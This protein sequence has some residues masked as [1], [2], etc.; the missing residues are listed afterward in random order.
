[1]LLFSKKKALSVL[2]GPPAPRYA[3]LQVLLE[4]TTVL[5]AWGDA[6]AF[7]LSCPG[8]LRR[9]HAALQ[10][11]SQ[12]TLPQCL[13]G[14]EAQLHAFAAGAVELRARMFFVPLPEMFASPDSLARVWAVCGGAAGGARPVHLRFGGTRSAR[15]MKAARN[16]LVLAENHT[17]PAV[18]ASR[19]P[20][21][22]GLVV[23]ALMRRLFTYA[24]G[25][26]RPAA[27]GGAILPALE[28]PPAL[29][30]TDL[31]GA[32]LLHEGSAN[33]RLGNENL[34]GDGVA[35]DGLEVISFAEFRSNAFAAGPVRGHSVDLRAAIA[36]ARRDGAP[37]VLLPWNLDHPGSTVPA[38]VE[39]TLHLQDPARPAVRLLIMPFN[40]PGQTGL[41]RKLIVQVRDDV[42]EGVTHLQHVFVGRLGHL[43]ALPRLRALAHVA[44]VDGNDPEHDWTLKRL[45][46]CGF[47]PLLLAADAAPAPPGI[48]AIPTDEALTIDAET[49]FG[50][51]SFYTH[52]PSLRA[53]RHLLPLTRALGAQLQTDGDDPEAVLA[54]NRRARRARRHSVAEQNGA[55][56]P[57]HGV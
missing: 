22:T 41:I 42:P 23:P 32:T 4:S 30:A 3:S 43:A 31:A 13:L 37:F 12:L 21:A 56:K 29:V 26:T 15:L 28:L 11:I 24:E 1:L 7:L 46:A 53:L 16:G 50:L 18:T 10:P 47:T 39:R 25:V 27:F 44:W 2:C 49:R 35:G 40:Y 14:S 57:A 5:R 6:P 55:E 17:T 45:A 54:A 33:E 20:F 8:P 51:L 38:L 9:H 19:H 52:L 34:A 36:A 48:T